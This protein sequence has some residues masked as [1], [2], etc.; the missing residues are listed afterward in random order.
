MTK[1]TTIEQKIIDKI[2]EL[3]PITSTPSIAMI[4]AQLAYESTHFTRT[5]EDLNYTAERLIQVFPKYFSQKTVGY[6][7]NNPERI[8]N[9]V[10]ADRMGNGGEA[11]GDGWLYRGR[12]FIQLTG[13][14]SYKK[15]APDYNPES[16]S[17][18]IDINISVSIKFILALPGFLIASNKGDVYTCTR[19]INGG[20]NGLDSRRVWYDNYLKM[21]S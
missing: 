8:A 21:F 18:N 11:S 10:Y 16:L 20:L 19:L 4:L 5:E 3:S 12:G 6:Y 13:K 7:A 14:A 2:K 15:Y 9:K 1:F 17:A